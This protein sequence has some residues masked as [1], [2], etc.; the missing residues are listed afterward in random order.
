MGINL[1]HE[2]MRKA[3]ADLQKAEQRLARDR[4]RAEREVA[5]F[6]GGGWTG[7]AADSFADAW[8]EWLAAADQVEAGLG[9]MSE[10]VDAAYL[11]LVH[12]DGESQR[13]LDRISQRI[14]DRL[15]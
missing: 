13:A 2:A 14:V 3:V 15:G 6:L 10:L 5:G 1:T 4:R 9:A 12:Q 7:A 11:D 8:T